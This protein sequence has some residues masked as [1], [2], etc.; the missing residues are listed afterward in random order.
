MA[1]SDLIKRYSLQPH[2]EGGYYTSTYQA[3]MLLSQQ[4]LPS[5]FK[6]DRPVSSAI[7]YLLEKGD[8]SSFHRIASDE[9][10][11]FYSGD[12]LWIHVLAP[13]GSYTRTTLGSK[14]DM[15]FQYIVLAGS[16]FASEPAPGS[17]FSFVG[18]TV[19]PGFHFDE[20]ELAT[21]NFLVSQ[22]PDQASLIARLCRSPL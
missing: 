20:F 14:E 11:H 12:P 21:T 2:P 13:D 18:C 17:T 22:F 19:S 9:C 16:W 5:V 15:T 7:Y 4:D 3:S 1:P 8:F 6:G 10:W